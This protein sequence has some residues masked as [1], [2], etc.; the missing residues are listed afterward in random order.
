M[1]P[2]PT[3]RRLGNR[4]DVTRNKIG[5]RIDR[6]PRRLFFWSRE[7]EVADLVNVSVSGAAVLASTCDDLRIGSLVTIKF[8]G[9]TGTVVIRRISSCGDL[10]RCLFGIEFAEPTSALTT[11]VYDTFLAEHGTPDRLHSNPSASTFALADRVGLSTL[12]GA[13]PP[14]WPS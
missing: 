5:W 6:R 3:E 14:T 8:R 12:P 7:P 2:D 11:L 10:S 4:Y 9:V 13:G 1:A